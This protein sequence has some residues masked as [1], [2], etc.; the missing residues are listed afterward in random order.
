MAS[1]W[2]ADVDIVMRKFSRNGKSIE[3]HGILSGFSGLSIKDKSSLIFGLAGIQ[4]PRFAHAPYNCARH[5]CRNSSVG[6]V[7]LGDFYGYQDV[8]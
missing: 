5:L 8:N 7:S 3:D 4:F 1:C 2:C 6:I